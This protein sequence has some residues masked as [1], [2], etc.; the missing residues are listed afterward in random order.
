MSLDLLD[1]LNLDGHNIIRSFHGNLKALINK[2]VEEAK[3]RS[4]FQDDDSRQLE[5]GHLLSIISSQDLRVPISRG[6]N[7]FNY[8]RQGFSGSS[9][10]ASKAY[11]MLGPEEMEDLLAK[12]DQQQDCAVAP[13]VTELATLKEIASIQRLADKL[14]EKSVHF[15]GFAAFQSL[16]RSLD[17]AVICN[18]SR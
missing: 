16:G 6:R 11:R 5:E 7:P 14:R 1:H 8:F 15:L 9:T 2:Y 18:S 12:C 17:P 13:E 10:D 4:L 3:G